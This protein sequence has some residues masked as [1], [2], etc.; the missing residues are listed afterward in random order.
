MKS[1]SQSRPARRFWLGTLPLILLPL[2]LL[3]FGLIVWASL[4][5]AAP[6]FAPAAWRAAQSDERLR[7]QRYDVLDDLRQNYLRYGTTRAQVLEWLGA[8]DA[9]DPLVF[10]S[11]E[12][13]YALGSSGLF[14]RDPIFLHVSFDE[15]DRLLETTVRG[16]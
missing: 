4:N 12:L 2:L 5:A 15:R 11:N 8:P 9:L 6:R 1:L 13:V 14:M 16:R 7:E 10:S 3:L